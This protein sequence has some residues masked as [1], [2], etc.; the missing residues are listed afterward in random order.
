MLNDF[1]T[2][3]ENWTKRVFLILFLLIDQSF[4]IGFEQLE[5]D[6]GKE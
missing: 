6:L 3:L 2:G 5:I 1:F 4:I